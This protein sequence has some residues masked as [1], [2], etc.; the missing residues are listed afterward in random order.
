MIPEVNGLSPN[1]QDEVDPVVKRVVTVKPGDVV[2]FR[3]DGYMTKEESDS[4]KAYVG[5]KMGDIPF[6]IV[7]KDFDI[8]V[9][10]RSERAPMIA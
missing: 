5:E 3:Y 9:L 10:K 2:I 6:L 4:L 1:G 7:N 8:T